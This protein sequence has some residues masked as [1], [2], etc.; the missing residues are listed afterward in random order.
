MPVESVS[1][2]WPMAGKKADGRSFPRSNCRISEAFG[3]QRLED[4]SLLR[5]S[6]GPFGAAP[7]LERK[8]LRSTVRPYGVAVATGV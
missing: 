5:L 2:S 8:S 7:P 4:W 1:A 6:L 3:L